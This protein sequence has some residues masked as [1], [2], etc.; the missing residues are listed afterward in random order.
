VLR[1][2][3][4]A[5]QPRQRPIEDD[6]DVAVRHAMPQEILYLPQLVM[7]L[8]RDRELHVELFWRQRL[9][10]RDAVHRYDG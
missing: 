3:Q 4:L 10:F 8:A 7:R 9:H 6:G 1:A 5:E 2:L